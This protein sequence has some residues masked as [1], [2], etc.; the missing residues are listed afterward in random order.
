MKVKEESE[1]FGLKLNIQK[2]KIIASGPITSWEIDGEIMETVCL[3]VG[4]QSQSVLLPWPL[5]W[6]CLIPREGTLWAVSV[7]PKVWPGLWP[8]SA[9]DTRLCLLRTFSQRSEVK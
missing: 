6:A 7:V 1:K 5:C 8:H 9:A 2:M 3:V 4:C